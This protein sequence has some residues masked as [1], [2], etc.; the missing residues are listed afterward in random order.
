MVAGWPVFCLY[1]EWVAVLFL[2]YGGGR[3]VAWE[4]FGLFWQ[5]QQASFDRV[6]D[7]TTVAAGQVGAAYAAGE[8]GIA[9]DEQIE[10]SEVQADAALGV[11]GGVNDLGWIGVQADFEAVLEAGVGGLGFRGVDAYPTGLN[12]HHLQE[13]DVVFIEEDGCSGEAFELECSADVVDVGVGDQDLFE[14]EVLAGQ[15]AMDAGD[16]VAGIDDDGFAGCRVA[17]DGAVALEWAYGEGFD[18]WGDGHRF[19]LVEGI[20]WGKKI[21]ADL[22]GPPRLLLKSD[23]NYLPGL[24][25]AET[26]AVP[27]IPENTEELEPLERR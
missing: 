1:E 23:P 17:Q 19:S 20:L 27:F 11:A 7:L 6:D 5:N 18:D 12:F 3:A 2:A 15:A 8:Q 10:W 14:L 26:G 4:D 22:I 13:R 24:A 16:V 21:E 9:C 25:G